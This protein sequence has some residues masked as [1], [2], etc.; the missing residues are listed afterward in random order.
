MT[1]AASSQ[2]EANTLREWENDDFIMQQTRLTKASKILNLSEDELAP[3][4][5]PKRALTV[6]VPAKM[7]DGSTATFIGYRVHYDLALGPGKGGVR[8][9][10][11]VNL[12]EV[13][14]MAMLM[15]WKCALMNLPFGGAHGGIRVDRTKLTKTELE[16]V[17]RRYTS[18]II[19]M[20]GPSSDIAGPDLNTDEQTM[21]WM[22]DTYSVNKGY[23]VPSIV[24]GKPKSL[25]GSYG[26]TESAG[27]GVVLSL[28]RYI[29]HYK[30]S[31]NETSV[32]IQGLGQLG[33]AVA[34]S[35]AASG[36]K[37]VGVSDS[38]GGLYNP[39]GINLADLNKHVKDQQSMKDF[40]EA[41]FMTNEE[42]LQSPCDVLIPCAVANQIHRSNASLLKC[43]LIVEGANAPTT[44]YADEVLE[45]NNIKLIPDILAN[46][47]SV[48][49][50]YF[51]WV[52]GLMRL[53]W[54]QEEVYERLSGLVNNVCDEVFNY[55]DNNNISMRMASMSIALNKVLT[56]RK[57]R[58]LYP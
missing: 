36:F 4:K 12:G 49:I 30:I 57:L 27:F 1:T 19:E 8:F 35:L 56:A 42:L 24:T 13:T 14:A 51:E 38:N 44:A 3:L 18:E 37:V 16:G 34:N 54:T 5:H 52:Q 26:L 6:I 23:T 28:K 47:A 17:T 22:M 31:K 32:I 46:T 2:K 29:Q 25:G 40:K 48:T 15:T 43:K 55:A 58:G 39:K 53:L 9:H 41:Q 10:P 50:G 11:N 7:D 33:S 20:I 45:A 21:A